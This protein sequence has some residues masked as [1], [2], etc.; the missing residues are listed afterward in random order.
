M[1]IRHLQSHADRAA[2]V[3][4]QRLIWGEAFSEV[5]PPSVLRVAQEI[6]G[7]C[8]GAFDKNDRMVGFVFGQ[9]GNRKGKSINWSQMLAVI[10]QQRGQGIA[11][12]LKLFQRDF[13]LQNN[14]EYICWTYDPLV[15]RNA[16]LNLN[17]L[18]VEID[19][20]V[21]DYY[22]RSNGSPLHAGMRLDRFIVEWSL[23]SG[24][25]ENAILGQ[26][27][28]IPETA[29]SFPVVNTKDDS[30]GQVVL[31]SNFTEH[32]GVRI[33]IPE[34]IENILLRAP[35]VADRWRE[36]T[37]KAFMHYLEKSYKITGFCGDKGRRYYVLTK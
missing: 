29:T 8:A 37:Q 24:R 16:H 20:Y 33:E 10:P 27:S 14:I 15:A 1:T 36:N 22:P 30:N 25:C 34:D 26:I 21:M 2:C 31:I 23:R 35:E 32:S 3:S 18:G 11:R 12:Q 6:G 13:C 19:S 4:L 7:I 28:E 9:I 5:V 17:K